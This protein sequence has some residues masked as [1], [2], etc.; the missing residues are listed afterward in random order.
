[1][2]LRDVPAASD[3]VAGIEDADDQGPTRIDDLA[4][5]TRRVYDVL[6]EGSD[7]ACVLIG[8]SYLS[9][10]LATALKGTLRESSVTEAIL[11]PGKVI[12]EYADRSALAY[13]LRLI[14][15]KAYQDLR[16]IEEIRDRFA[17][18]H[19]AVTFRDAGIREACDK[20]KTCEILEAGESS[21]RRTEGVHDQL[22]D[23]ARDRFVVTTVF[24]ASRISAA[25]R[26][27]NK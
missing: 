13:C 14:E 27:A 7:L 5:D 8:A 26:H 2:A 24:L 23:A 9:E 25:G 3:E 11:R 16:I 19:A 1:M 10:V 20:L 21:S 12:G 22:A 18:E 15:K 17:A 6:N 4:Q